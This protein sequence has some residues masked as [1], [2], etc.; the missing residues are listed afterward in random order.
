[1]LSEL[2][3]VTVW[4]QNKR[5][6]DRKG[7]ADPWTEDAPAD[8]ELPTLSSQNAVA[9]TASAPSTL[10][11]SSRFNRSAS[12]A[13]ASLLPTTSTP[14]KAAFARTQSLSTLSLDAF[15]TRAHAPATPPRRRL[16]SIAT[17]A[18]EP[19][20]ARSLAAVLENL[21]ASPETPAA[22]ASTTPEA[23]REFV[24]LGRRRRCTTLEW[25]CAAAR[26][27]GGGDREK[28]LT[29]TKPAKASREASPSRGNSSRPSR[30]GKGRL[31]ESK[32]MEVDDT[33]DEHEAITPRGSLGGDHGG[34]LPAVAVASPPWKIPKQIGAKASMDP[35]MH[36]EEMMRAA[37]ALCGLGRA[38]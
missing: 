17:P 4:F 12:L 24:E 9:A 2:R 31:V 11:S 25:A 21:P 28:G 26:L 27:D 1:M 37:L 8:S 3:S 6:L 15:A 32:A 5:Q 16:L 30:R 18:R 23:A 10:R 7:R 14:R 38:S 33:D 20:E 13:S 22:G 35:G 34:W 19:A 36:D 29:P